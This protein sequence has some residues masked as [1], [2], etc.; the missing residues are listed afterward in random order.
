MVFAAAL[1][2]VLTSASSEG[3][4]QQGDARGCSGV[5][6]EAVELSAPPAAGAERVEWLERYLQ[7]CDVL[8]RCRDS[9]MLPVSK[10]ELARCLHARSRTHEAIHFYEV[11]QGSEVS[12]PRFVE[13]ATDA[14]RALKSRP[15]I[16][17][18][19]SLEVLT[20]PPGFELKVDGRRV[21]PTEW[22][23]QTVTAGSHE[24]TATAPDHVPWAAKL[25]LSPGAT[26]RVVVPQLERFPPPRP[27]PPG[28]PNALLTVVTLGTGAVTVGALGWFLIEQRAANEDFATHA[29]TTS[30]AERDRT[31]SKV[32]DS[33]D[34]R[35]AARAVLIGAAATFAVSAAVTA[36]EWGLRADPAD[37]ESPQLSGLLDPTREGAGVILEGSF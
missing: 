27:P 20:R 33:R 37:E 14:I 19:L 35:N 31:W 30:Q 18:R 34:R 10:L 36:L 28:S 9:L 12:A 11:V 26:I 21:E 6:T 25:E 24:L 4:A 23:D 1:A 32:E 22:T 16:S 15:P 8:E 17:S 5:E 29:A 7:R 13:E 2:L 3:Q